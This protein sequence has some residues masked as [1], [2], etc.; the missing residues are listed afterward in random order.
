MVPC[1]ASAVS[2]RPHQ[3]HIRF[4]SLRRDG[5][6]RGTHGRARHD[7]QGQPPK[8]DA[9]LAHEPE[10]PTCLSSEHARPTTGSRP[11]SGRSVSRFRPLEATALRSGILRVLVTVQ[12]TR[13]LCYAEA[14]AKLDANLG[15]NTHNA[16]SWRDGMG[17]LKSRA[18]AAGRLLTGIA[19][20]GT[21]STT[22]RFLPP[23]AKVIAEAKRRRGH[24]AW[25]LQRHERL[26]GSISFQTPLILRPFLTRY[27]NENLPIAPQC[28]SP[29]S[30]AGRGDLPH[31]CH[32]HPAWPQARRRRLQWASGCGTLRR[33]HHVQSKGV[34]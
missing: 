21:Q 31:R 5:W 3:L 4:N 19:V 9:R 34:S 8:D 7:H 22:R 32:I 16:L 10:P 17:G 29:R 25:S 30:G 13:S 12:R 20:R 27:D 2:S 6:A 24:T 26:A 15:E 11:S 18:R 23:N 14:V 1:V 33:P 28:N